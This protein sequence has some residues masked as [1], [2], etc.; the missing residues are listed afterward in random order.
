[1][2]EGEGEEGEEG[3]EGEEEVM[4]E[5]MEIGDAHTHTSLPQKIDTRHTLIILRTEKAL[6]DIFRF[7]FP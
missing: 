2:G 1:M 3:R 6:F 4:E 5:V 7:S